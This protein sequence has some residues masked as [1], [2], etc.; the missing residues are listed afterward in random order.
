M[1]NHI[2]EIRRKRLHLP[3]PSLSRIAKVPLEAVKSILQDPSTAEAYQR[4][5]ICK[6]LGV[7]YDGK[8]KTPLKTILKKRINQ[9]AIYV[10]KLVQGTQ[11]LEA[12]AV[13]AKDFQTIVKAAE[14]ALLAGPLRKIWDED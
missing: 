4:D 8:R 11:A 9:K 13:T 1:K 5:S 10:A 7:D 6:V 2:L 14:T 12:S 3:L